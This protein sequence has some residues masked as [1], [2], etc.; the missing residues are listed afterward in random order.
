MIGQFVFSQDES[1]E[2]L[3]QH[4][5]RTCWYACLFAQYAVV[6]DTHLHAS[7]VGAYAGRCTLFVAQEL[8]CTGHLN[9][10]SVIYTYNWRFDGGGE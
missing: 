9:V 7:D 1:L 5:W 3:R 8:K 4:V 2:A 10:G 6:G